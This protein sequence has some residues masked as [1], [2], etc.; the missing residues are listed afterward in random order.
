MTSRNSAGH[1]FSMACRLTGHNSTKRRRFLGCCSIRTHNSVK[2]NFIRVFF[3]ALLISMATLIYRMPIS[4]I[5]P[6]SMVLY[7]IKKR[8]LQNSGGALNFL[9][10]SGKNEAFASESGMVCLRQTTSRIGTRTCLYARR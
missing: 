6:Y 9:L 2:R 1:S 10:E 3:L 5:F 8:F 4:T 7:S